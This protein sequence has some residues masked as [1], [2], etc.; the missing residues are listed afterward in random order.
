MLLLEVSTLCDIFVLMGHW[1][2]MKLYANL[3]FYVGGKY[4]TERFYTYTQHFLQLL[5]TSD[6]TMIILLTCLVGKL[7]LT[8]HSRACSR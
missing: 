7:A 6:E 8:R 2:N 1:G 3:F 5:H 4:T